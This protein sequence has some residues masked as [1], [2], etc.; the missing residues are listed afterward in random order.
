MRGWKSSAH[1]LDNLID[2]RAVLE[3]TVYSLC[4]NP[5]EED[6][7]SKRIKDRHVR[8]RA[9]LMSP[10]QVQTIRSFLIFAAA[11]AKNRESFRPIVDAALESVWL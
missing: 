5:E 9:K 4:P 8:D 6:Y 2:E 7:V 11:K 3:L 10:Q 1:R